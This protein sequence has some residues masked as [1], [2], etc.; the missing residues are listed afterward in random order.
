MSYPAIMVYVEAK[1][2]PEQ[3]VRLAASISEK[4]NATLI[5]VSALAMPPQTAGNG[6]TIPAVLDAD[7]KEMAAILS[8]TETWFRKTAEPLHR[9]L[10]WR[11]EIGFPTAILV[12][13]ARAADLLVVGRSDPPG[14]IYSTVDLA[15]AVLN[16]GR[17]VLVVPKGVSTLRGRHVVIGWKDTREARRAVVDALPFLQE[18]DTVAIVEIYDSDETG[19]PQKRID[20]VAH[21]LERHK[22]PVG[23]KISVRRKQSDAAQLI[24]VTQDAGGDL[25]IT[26]AY[27]HSRVGEWIFGGVTRELLASSPICCLMSH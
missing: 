3:R 21:F 27:G 26:G 11:S 13:E 16:A 6:V 4:F 12:R 18:A 8:R 24:R 7:T 9:R 2:Q 1:A 15:G 17:P 14:D 23:P 5:G 25:L 19:S 22:V 20:D 10:E